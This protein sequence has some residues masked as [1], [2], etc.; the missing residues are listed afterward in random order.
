M[1]KQLL[2][3]LLATA[4]TFGPLSADDTC[5][6]QAHLTQPTGSM[7]DGQVMHLA[8]FISAEAG[9]E[10]M[11][12]QDAIARVTLLQDNHRRSLCSRWEAG[13][14]TGFNAIMDSNG[15][16][17]SEIYFQLKCVFR[18]AVGVDL[19]RTGV[20]NIGNYENLMIE[21]MY[22]MQDEQPN[23]SEVFTCALINII[24]ENQNLMRYIDSQ[25]RIALDNNLNAV[26]S[27]LQ[28]LKTEFEFHLD[29][30]PVNNPDVNCPEWSRESVLSARVGF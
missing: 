18:E 11:P 22:T 24:D 13:D 28:I 25:I 6:N 7:G 12:A 16:R 4:F 15:Y 17:L 2:T 27:R 23:G 5:I 10:R 14:W 3:L 8:N 29:D 1:A 20:T 21:V 30:Y 19:L 9:A 26:A